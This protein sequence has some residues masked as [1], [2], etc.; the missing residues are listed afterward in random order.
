MRRSGVR[1]CRARSGTL[2]VAGRWRAGPRQRPEG[3]RDRAFP[4]DRTS[5]EAPSPAV[6]DGG[7]CLSERAWR[8]E[9]GAAQSAMR[10]RPASTAGHCPG[11]GN[12]R[13]TWSTTRPAST[14]GHVSAG[15]AGFLGRS[16]GTR[17][18]IGRTAASQN[19]RT[20]PTSTEDHRVEGHSRCSSLHRRRHRHRRHPAFPGRG[21]AVRRRVELRPRTSLT[22]ECTARGDA[23]V[24]PLKPMPGWNP[25]PAGHACVLFAACRR[26]RVR[27]PGEADARGG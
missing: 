23:P 2:V 4:P 9:A 20:A 21:T 11:A 18:M 8:A 26:G 13:S 5:R 15:G 6:R 16:P 14:H 3:A 25:R 12:P 17:S 7:S 22:G 10:L 24:L 1:T 27:T 19:R